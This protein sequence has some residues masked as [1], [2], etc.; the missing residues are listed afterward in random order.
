MLLVISYLSLN[1]G[2]DKV[3]DIFEFW[4]G[5]RTNDIASTCI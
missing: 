4:E 2:E 5:L 3:T 1:D